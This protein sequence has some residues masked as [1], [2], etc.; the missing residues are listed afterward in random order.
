M[1]HFMYIF[2]SNV[3]SDI[4]YVIPMSN[5]LLHKFLNKGNAN[6]YEYSYNVNITI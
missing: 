2:Q 1:P 5:E 4:C 3:G 6:K